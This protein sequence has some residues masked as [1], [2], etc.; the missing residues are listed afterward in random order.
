V[1]GLLAGARR[2]GVAARW[3]F[4]S[5]SYVDL[6]PDHRAT[7]A[8]LGSARSGTTWVGEVI[9][10]HHDHRVV[11]EPLRP[12]RVPVARSFANGQY[13]RRS[14][15]DPRF[16]DPMRA[17]LTGRVRNPWTDHLN[18]VVVARRRLVKEIRANLLAPWLV[19]QFPGMPVVLLVRHP[20]GVAVSRREMG[21]QDHLDDALA[22]PDLVADHLHP[23]QATWLHGLTHPFARSV[24]QA[25]LETLVPLRM[26]TPDELLVVTYEG[27]VS[28]PREQAERV[29]RH[30]GQQP[31]AALDA[32]LD[33]PSHLARADSAVR[34]GGDR[35][36]SWLRRVSPE[37]TAAAAEVLAMLGLDVA[38]GV[39]DPYPYAGA[40]DALHGAPYAGPG[41]APAGTG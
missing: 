2:L 4:K 11:F 16:L 1:D 37:E 6:A 9:D 5:L 26:T 17:I 40:L 41:A 23:E 39:D 33:R 35:A 8:L 14:D 15:T 34:T 25:G 13:L 7:V 30:V 38:Y 18:H 27:L 12:N 31:D 32:A 10:R 28:Q 3:R 24:A 20:L 36:A 29:L 19:E 22:Q 21:W